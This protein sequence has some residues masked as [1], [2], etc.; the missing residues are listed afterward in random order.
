MVMVF[1]LAGCEKAPELVDS[2]GNYDECYY[3]GVY[4]SGIG[5]Y[6]CDNEKLSVSDYNNL[7]TLDNQYYTNEE[8]DSMLQEQAME[9]MKLMFDNYVEYDEFNN[10]LYSN[11]VIVDGMKHC[12]IVLNLNDDTLEQRISELELLHTYKIYYFNETQYIYVMY[13]NGL[14][15]YDITMFGGCIEKC[16]VSEYPND[17]NFTQN[18]F[19]TWWES[20]IEFYQDYIDNGSE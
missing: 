17:E 11:C 19:D 13:T 18:E 3:I 9:L 1:M 15:E 14:D 8:V 20:K 10:M 4:G 6:E 16:E 5:N 7:K 2:V 12:D